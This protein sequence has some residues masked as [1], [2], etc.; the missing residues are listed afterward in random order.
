[1]L[2]EL[3]IGFKGFGDVIVTSDL[4]VNWMRSDSLSRKHF[5]VMQYLSRMLNTHNAIFKYLAKLPKFNFVIPS[6]NIH[7]FCAISRP[8]KDSQ[9]CKNFLDKFR[10]QEYSRK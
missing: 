4:K 8:D 10:L 2:L 6:Y 9:S 5:Y 1:L 3:S 7:R